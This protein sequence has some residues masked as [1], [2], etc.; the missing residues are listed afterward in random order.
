[1]RGLALGMEAGEVP[2]E[3]RSMGCTEG[4]DEY[5]DTEDSARILMLQLRH[6]I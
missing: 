4:I 6:C 3:K 1:M 5:Q 2:C